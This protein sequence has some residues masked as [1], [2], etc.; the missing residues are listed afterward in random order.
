MDSVSVSELR[1]NISH[2]LD[3]VARGNRLIIRDEKRNVAVAQLTCAPSFD[4]HLYEKSLREAA[5]VFSE[6]NHPEWETSE[7]VSEWLTK[8]RSVDERSF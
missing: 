7:K 4:R 2:Y 8:N 6:K 3:R 1:N 5:G